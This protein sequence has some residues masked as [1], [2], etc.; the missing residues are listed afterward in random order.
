MLV[1]KKCCN[2]DKKKKKCRKNQNSLMFRVGHD[3]AGIK[4][5]VK[6]NTSMIFALAVMFFAMFM[7]I[8]YVVGASSNKN[9][10]NE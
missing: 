6:W 7:S 8:S 4:L 3:K 9:E 5:L 2:K 1:E 10:D